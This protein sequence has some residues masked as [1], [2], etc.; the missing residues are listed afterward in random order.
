M[1]QVFEDE[2]LFPAR[3]FFAMGGCDA[4]VEFDYYGD[5][6]ADGVGA[7]VEGFADAEAGAEGGFVCGAEDGRAVEDGW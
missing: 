5:V 3:R 7:D 4:G 6:G 2:M 1:I